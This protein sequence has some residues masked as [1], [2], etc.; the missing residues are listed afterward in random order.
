MKHDDGKDANVFVIDDDDAIAGV[1]TTVLTD[2]D[3]HVSSFSNGRD[4]ISEVKKQQPD[5][6]IIDYVLPGERIEDVILSLRRER[7]K[8]IPFIMMSAHISAAQ[9]AKRMGI[10]R[11]LAKPFQRD[12]VLEAISMSL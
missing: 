5:V 12:T 2:A 4:A 6:V 9:E 3:F 10:N 1:L 8:D 7:E 11:F